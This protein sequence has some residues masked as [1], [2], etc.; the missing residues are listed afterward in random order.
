MVGLPIWYAVTSALSGTGSY[1]ERMRR[2]LEHS[3]NELPLVIDE[4]MTIMDIEL[5]NRDF[6]YHITVKTDLENLKAM[7]S[8]FERKDQFDYCNSGNLLEQKTAKMRTISRYKTHDKSDVVF[9]TISSSE[10]CEF[11]IM[12]S[13][14]YTR[15]I[16]PS[17]AIKLEYEYLNFF[18]PIELDDNF[19]ILQFSEGN[20][21][22]Q[23]NASTKSVFDDLEGTILVTI[24]AIREVNQ[25]RTTT[26]V[27]LNMVWNNA[28]AIGRLS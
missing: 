5:E 1:E 28:N 16:N 11:Q 24:L 21:L 27:M 2:G 19:S 15:T 23:I 4:Y 22:V 25:T 13:G 20:V 26:L 9:E 14:L 7:R 6:I 17:E 3:K 12:S 8:F 18:T 10:K